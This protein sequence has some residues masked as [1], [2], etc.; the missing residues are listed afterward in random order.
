MKS[1]TNHKQKQRGV[2]PHFTMVYRSGGYAHYH[3]TEGSSI[4]VSASHFTINYQTAGYLIRTQQCYCISP[5]GEEDRNQF[6]S[7][8]WLRL[9]QRHPLCTLLYCSHTPILTSHT[10]IP[11]GFSSALP[12]SKS[13]FTAHTKWYGTIS[14]A[15]RHHTPL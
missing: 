11:P 10:H 9:H 3:F 6:T 14:I 13:L 5:M 15:G 8:L 2:C 12:W 4:I 7:S 1:L